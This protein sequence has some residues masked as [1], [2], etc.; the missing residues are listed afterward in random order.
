MCRHN[1]SLGHKGTL[2]DVSDSVVLCSASLN[3]KSTVP[4]VP[5][6]LGL[7]SASLD[8]KNTVPDVLVVP[9]TAVLGSEK[10][11]ISAAAIIA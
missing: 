7:C 4:D 2:P 9:C 11:R 1:A 10:Y 8:R 6:V 5:V 3:R